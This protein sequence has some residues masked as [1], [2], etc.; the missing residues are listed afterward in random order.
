MEYHFHHMLV[1]WIIQL[2]DYDTRYH[3]FVSPIISQAQCGDTLCAITVSNI[4]EYHASQIKW[5]QIKFIFHKYIDILQ[6]IHDN[7]AYSWEVNQISWCLS[8]WLPFERKRKGRKRKCCYG[9]KSFKTKVISPATRLVVKQFV[10]SN[11]TEDANRWLVDSL[12][13][14]VNNA[15]N[16]SMLSGYDLILHKMNPMPLVVLN[17]VVRFPPTHIYIYIIY[18]DIYIYDTYI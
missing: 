14:W 13:I 17:L 18:I 10:W 5:N 11:I 9:N 3:N 2:Y 15:D 12:H 4:H 6:G 1:R 8:S 7:K 16:V